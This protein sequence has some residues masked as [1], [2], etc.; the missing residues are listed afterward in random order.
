MV[1]KIYS[2]ISLTLGGVAEIKTRS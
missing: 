2:L 1:K